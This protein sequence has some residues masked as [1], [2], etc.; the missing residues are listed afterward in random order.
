MAG[1]AHPRAEAAFGPTAESYELGRPGWPAAALDV[2][3]R[4]LGLDGG[5]RV[6]DLAAGTGKL[7]RELAGRYARVY[8]V[9]PVDGMRA[10]LERTVP[11][12]TVLSG[13]AEAI[14][15]PGGAV[16]AV[17]V[18]DAFHWFDPVAALAEIR[19]VAAGL[20]VLWHR[21]DWDAATEPWLRELDDVFSAHQAPPVA[22]PDHGSWRE[23]LAD[24]TRD[25]VA[26]PQQVP[27][28]RLEPLYT[29]FSSIGALDPHAR[30]AA[31]AE[32]N[33]VLPR[34]GID[35][36]DLDYRIEIQTLRW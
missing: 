21:F 6:L 14:P 16:D 2:V 4:R 13:S 32:L 8:A 17:L 34:H 1:R 28:D 36:L 12:A 5:S 18:G 27:A 30:A 31:L 19:R 3:D 25:E 7:T 9:E 20:A 10:V 33:A 15:L 26:D 35:R 11:G 24:A 23:H 22:D 29:S